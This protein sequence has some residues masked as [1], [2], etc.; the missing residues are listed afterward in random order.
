MA[1]IFQKGKR[2]VI[3]LFLFIYLGSISI[4]TSQERSF[5]NWY[6][7]E[8][9]K[10]NVKEFIY[11]KSIINWNTFITD[12]KNNN[13]NFIEK[14]IFNYNFFVENTNWIIYREPIKIDSIFNNKDILHFKNQIQGRKLKLKNNVQFPVIR[15]LSKTDFNGIEKCIHFFSTPLFSRDRRYVILATTNNNSSNNNEIVVRLFKKIN[16]KSWLPLR[17]MVFHNSCYKII[18]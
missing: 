10:D 12:N 1:I 6:V 17:V 7:K 14:D 16:N 5:L 15:N 11:S 8:I 4:T 13:S 18:N 9:K 2:P 3:N